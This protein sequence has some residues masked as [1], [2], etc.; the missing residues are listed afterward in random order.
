MRGIVEQIGEEVRHLALALRPISLDE[1][2]LLATL[3]NYIADWSK[4]AQV[5]V[6]LHSRGLGKLRLPPQIET[7]I[8][9]IVQE[10][11]TNVLRHAQAR[12]VSLILERRADHVQVVVEDD[13]RGFDVEA[14]LGSPNVELRL[15]LLGMQE[16]AAMVGGQLTIESSNGRGTSLFL[17][18]PYTLEWTGG[19]H[20]EAADPPR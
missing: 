8:Y 17:R 2:G 10:A 16:R 19:A 12:S 6:D 14:L 3:N 9:R 15:G 7:A 11:L 20:D 4:Q 5:A 18:V 13:G 1:Q